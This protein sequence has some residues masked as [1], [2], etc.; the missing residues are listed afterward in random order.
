MT[1]TGI[2]KNWRVQ[3]GIS[4]QAI[5][6]STKLSVRHLEAIECGDFKKLPGGIYNT[7]YIRQYA[8]AIDFDEADLLA[9]Y[10]KFC[11]PPVDTSAKR[12]VSR[13]T[14]LLFQH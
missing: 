1:D 9:Y 5:A 6:A 8:R 2:L 3:K 13:T 10:Q 12:P 14:G 11:D 7:N 4:L